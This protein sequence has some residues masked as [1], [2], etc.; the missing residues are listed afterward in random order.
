MSSPTHKLCDIQD[1][2]RISRLHI[3]LTHNDHDTNHNKTMHRFA[4]CFQHREDLIQYIERFL[5]DHCKVERE[6]LWFRPG[7]AVTREYHVR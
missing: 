7:A 3:L 1:C 2:A 4:L 5:K 6:R